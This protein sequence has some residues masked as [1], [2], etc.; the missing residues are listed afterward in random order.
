M[1]GERRDS[2]G[3][4][5]SA[6]GKLARVVLL[7]YCEFLGIFNVHSLMARLSCVVVCRVYFDG[8]LLPEI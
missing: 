4:E 3:S 7:D 2:A 8:Q 6:G 1:Y 5:S